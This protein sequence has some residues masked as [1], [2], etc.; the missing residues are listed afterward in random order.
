MRYVLKP[1][2]VFLIYISMVIIFLSAAI[3]AREDAALG[4]MFMTLFFESICFP[5]IVALGIRGLGRHT[6]RGSGFIVGAVVGGA[7]V[8]PITGAVGDARGTALAMVVPVCWFVITWSYAVCVN[9]VPSYR[10]PAD[11]LGSSDIGMSNETKKVDEE[12]HPQVSHVERGNLN[13]M[14]QME[15]KDQEY[16]PA[17]PM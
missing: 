11:A 15:K 4:M 10:D 17:G 3:G 13:D 8:P 2:W 14:T 6:K 5:T 9:F 12:S 7:V 16:A 1:R